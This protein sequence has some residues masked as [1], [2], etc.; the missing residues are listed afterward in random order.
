MQ[1]QAYAHLKMWQ[2]AIKH[3]NLIITLYNRVNMHRIVADTGPLLV[4]GIIN[5]L[6]LL[7]NLYASVYVSTEVKRELE[8]GAGKYQDARNA[9][10]AVNKGWL[11]EIPVDQ[12]FGNRIGELMAGPP[13]LGKAQAE[14]IVLCKQLN[15]HLLLIDDEDAV[16]VA[17]KEGIR[18]V[19][20]LDILINSAKMGSISLSEA[21]NHINKFREAGEYGEKDLR[22]AESR[23]KRIAGK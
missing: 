3:L 5:R 9:L 8:I 19:H 7:V 21:L 20:G 4:L 16:K 10:E 6:D 18:V 22:E 23:I 12:I 11:T 1:E 15:I 17:Q 13:K 14:S 2:F